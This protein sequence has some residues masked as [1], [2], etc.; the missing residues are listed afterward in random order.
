M[1][2]YVRTQLECVELGL[3]HCGFFVAGRSPEEIVRVPQTAIPYEIRRQLTVGKILHAKV[4]A[5]VP[6]GMTPMFDSWE[7]N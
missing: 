5:G 6:C 1:A 3:L 4:E 7:L 2:E